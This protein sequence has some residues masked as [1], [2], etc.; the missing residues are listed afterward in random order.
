MNRPVVIV[1]GWLSSP[2][3]Y[4]AM[5]RVLAAPPYNRVVYITDINR[6]EWASLRD[7]H[8]SPVL[9][10]VANTVQLALRETGAE[11]VDLIGH[12]AGGRVAR[13][14]LGHQPYAGVVYDGQRYVASLT[15]LGTA[16]ETYEV[17]VK[18][19]A[20]QV[21]A[22]YPGAYYEHI[23][24]RSVAGESVK[25]R[26]YGSPEEMLAYQSYETAFGNGEQIGD[27]IIPTVSCYLA[28]AD[29]LVLKGARHAPYNAPSNW[30]GARSVIPLW[31]E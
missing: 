23:Q 10:V 25:G 11:R 20:A 5:A 21:N 26:K 3:D 14:Y 15:T 28:G 31:Y 13:A 27:G 1:G 16:H 30:Y 22:F 19:F 17:W 18:E 4:T 12:S 6:L 24:Y 9:D 2:A 7:P 29:N 8:F